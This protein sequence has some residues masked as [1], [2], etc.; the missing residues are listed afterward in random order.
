MSRRRQLKQP[1]IKQ[2]LETDESYYVQSEGGFTLYGVTPD[3]LRIE[4]VDL[5][6][7]TRFTLVLH[8]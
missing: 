5:H 6:G 8:K 4:V 1:Q 2:Q 3:K 7:R